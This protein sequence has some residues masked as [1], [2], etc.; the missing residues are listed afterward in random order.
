M[1]KGHYL[2]TIMSLLGVGQASKRH[3]VETTTECPPCEMIAKRTDELSDES[4]ARLRHIESALF[5]RGTAE[6]VK[7]LHRNDPRRLRLI[8]ERAGRIK[9][10][11]Q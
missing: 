11:A 9:G 2:G 6:G 4:R 7:Y 10:R 8:A 3:D 1:G 5:L